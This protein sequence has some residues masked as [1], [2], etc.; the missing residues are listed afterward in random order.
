MVGYWGG[1]RSSTSSGRLG[2]LLWGNSYCM[3]REQTK[4]RNKQLQRATGEGNREEGEKDIGRERRIGIERRRG[5]E[6]VN[7]WA[8]YQTS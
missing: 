4:Y 1:G 8:S 3:E 2:M 5:R 7:C 6:I